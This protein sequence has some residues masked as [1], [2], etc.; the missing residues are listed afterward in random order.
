MEETREEAREAL[1]LEQDARYALTVCRLMV[2]KRV[3]QIVRAVAE[4]PAD[5]RLLVAGDGDMLEGGGV[6]R[7]ISAWGT[8]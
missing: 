6:S 2:W 5:V 4:L 8:A 3:D 7:P 1:G